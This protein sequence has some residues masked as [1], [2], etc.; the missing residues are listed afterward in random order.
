MITTK[1][2]NIIDRWNTLLVE[3]PF[4]GMEHYIMLDHHINREIVDVLCGECEEVFKINIFECL[5]QYN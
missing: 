5:G 3:C 4:C 1:K 2:G